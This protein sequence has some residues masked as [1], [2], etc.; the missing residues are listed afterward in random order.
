MKQQIHT[1][2]NWKSYIKYLQ[3]IIKNKIDESV[4]LFDEYISQKSKEMTE[5]CITD[6]DFQSRIHVRKLTSSYMETKQFEHEL[7]QLKHEALEEFIK[8]HVLSER[9]KFEKKPSS[10]SLQTL[11][12]YI[13]K[14]KKDFQTNK[15]YVGWK[16]EQLKEIPKLLERIMLY[17]RCFLLQLPLYE[18]SQELLEKIENNTVITISTSTGS[19]KL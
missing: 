1:T 12:E 6:P 2:Q 3:E 17:Y 9:A 7:E 16:F 19:G 13:D 5:Q 15:I 11:N 8:Q 18:T 14:V 10:K 4:K